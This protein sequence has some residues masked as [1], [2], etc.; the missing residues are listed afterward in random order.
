MEAE[1]YSK[2]SGHFHRTPPQKKNE[3]QQ[4]ICLSP[5]QQCFIYLIGH[6]ILSSDHHQVIHTQNLKQFTFKG[7]GHPAIGRGGPKGSG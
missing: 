4:Q 5:T 6:K 1:Y 7:K 3:R 2:N